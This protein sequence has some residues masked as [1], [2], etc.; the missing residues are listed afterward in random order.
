MSLSSDKIL[1]ITRSRKGHGHHFWNS[2]GILLLN[3]MPHKTKITWDVYAAVL[4]KLEDTEEGQQG[5]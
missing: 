2:E 4:W 3:Y 1:G 5:I